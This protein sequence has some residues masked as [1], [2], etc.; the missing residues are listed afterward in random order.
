[1]FS[2]ISGNVE[3]KKERIK[4]KPCLSELDRDDRT[5]HEIN[6]VIPRPAL[7]GV[8]PVTFRLVG[9]KHGK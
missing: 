8:T 7:G 5:A 4:K 9:N 6:W 1:M 2:I 3:K